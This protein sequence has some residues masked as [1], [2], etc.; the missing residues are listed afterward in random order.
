MSIGVSVGVVWGD[1]WGSVVDGAELLEMDAS[2]SW[3][4]QDGC[5]L[6]GLDATVVID[7]KLVEVD[8]DQ[9][10]SVSRDKSSVLGRR[11]AG[12]DATFVVVDLASQQVRELESGFHLFA[13]F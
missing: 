4:S 5:T 2:P 11:T 6:V 12:D 8:L 9:V 1:R 3:V 13:T 7:G 10:F